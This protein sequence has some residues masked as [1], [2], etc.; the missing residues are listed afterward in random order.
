MN[1]PEIMKRNMPHREIDTKRCI[2]FSDS[3]RESM[4]FGK[5]KN[6][7]IS[8]DTLIMVSMTN[9]YVEGSSQLTGACGQ[10]VR[11]HLRNT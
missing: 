8:L 6:G 11:N 7:S 5:E 10:T 2:K 1:L 9:S 3:V 4:G